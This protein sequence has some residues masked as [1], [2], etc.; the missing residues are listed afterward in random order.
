[1][2]YLYKAQLQELRN[3]LQVLRQN[4][5]ATLRTQIDSL[6]RDIEGLNSQFTD[7]LTQLK[8]EIS[9]DMHNRKSESREVSQQTDL[10]VQDINHKL[11]LKLS[12]VRTSIE[13]MKMSTTRSVVWVAIAT[14]GGL[15]LMDWASSANNATTK[16]P[17]PSAQA[18]TL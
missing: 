13:A 14:F 18:D 8:A 17:S 7:Y 4:D 10:L 2:M 6:R 3:E 1:E 5:N 16:R 9:M 15:T 12:D 11:I